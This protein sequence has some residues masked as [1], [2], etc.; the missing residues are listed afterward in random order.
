MKSLKSLIRVCLRF[1]FSRLYLAHR[2]CTPILEHHSATWQ[3]SGHV[4]LCGVDEPRPRKSG[5][6]VCCLTA[7]SVQWWPIRLK[8]SYRWAEPWRRAE[9]GFPKWM[10]LRRALWRWASWLELEGF[11]WLLSSFCHEL[12]AEKVWKE[13]LD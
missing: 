2:R 7:F 3:H 9:R 11:F 1:C 5:G 10:E 13:K 4:L 6:G 12:R 8:R